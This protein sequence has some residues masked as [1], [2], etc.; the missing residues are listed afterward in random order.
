MKRFTLLALLLALLL[1]TFVLLSRPGPLFSQSAANL[2][3]EPLLPD[4]P[5]RIWRSPTYASNHTLY[6]TTDRDLRRSVDEGES[7]TIL[8][9]QAPLTETVGIS[10]LAVAPAGESPATL[11]LARN[12]PGGPAEIYRRQDGALTWSTVFSTTAGPIYDLAAA[13]DGN[14]QLVVLAVGG[15][16]VW[17]SSDGGD[18]WTPAE[19]GLPDWADLYRVYP[20]PAFPADGT[21]YLTGFGSLIRSGD[22]GQSWNVVSIPDVD[23]ARQVVFSPQYAT[24][25]TLWVSYFFIE[26]SGDSDP[27]GV[28]RSTDGGQTWQII[29]EGLPVD[30]LDGWIMGLAVSPDYPADASLYAIERTLV[31]TGTT[32]A[33]YR[34]PAGQDTWIKQGTAP[35]ATPNGLLAAAPDL[36]FLPT[37]GG[38]WRLRSHCWE[39]L[40]NGDAERN[41]G[42]EMPVTPVT[43]AYTTDQAHGGVRAIRM[44]IVNAPNQYAYSSARQR[45]TLPAGVSPITLNFWLY[46]V[47][48]AGQMASPA[49]AGV[50][51]AGDAQY[52]LILD[53]HLNILETLLWTLSNAATWQPYSFDLSAYAGQTIWLHFGVYN[54]GAGGVTGLYLDD[55]SLVGCEPPPA[56]TTAVYLPIIQAGTDPAGW[57]LIDGQ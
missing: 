21:V 3:W 46:P 41:V 10:G 11:L 28:V 7:W 29:N 22:G 1:T 19:S 2:T 49:Q 39:W 26:G 5:T 14:G 30:Y 8:Y 48:T 44:G 23:V 32:W 9:P 17:R 20:S 50:P 40:V 15:P 56:P 12:R 54:D 42:W 45:V 27:N 55:A 31:Y 18:T 25:Q 34:A 16:H 35:D 13:Y 51:A 36:F 52:V 4:L 47:S 53:E 38:L 57:L 33:L 6:V 43:A 37:Q 24:D